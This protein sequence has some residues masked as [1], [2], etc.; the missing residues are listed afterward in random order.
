MVARFINLA[1]GQ[2]IPVL[3]IEVQNDKYFPKVVAIL[4]AAS[5]LY[6]IIEWKQSSRKSRYSLWSIA[7]IFT[8]L[9]FACISFWFSHSLIAKGTSFE[10]ISPVWYFTFF[11]IGF[12]LGLIVFE[13]TFALLMIRTPK[14]AKKLRLPRVPLATR[15]TFIVCFP[16]IFLLV[17][18]YYVFSIFSPEPIKGLAFYLFCI[19]IIIMFGEGFF[20]LFVKRDDNGKLIPFSK[21]I[22][23]LKKSYD[24]HDYSYL[25]I[26]H[27]NQAV[28]ELQISSTDSP[29][30]IQKVMQKRF[31]AKAIHFHV[32][33]EEEIQVSFYQKDGNPD[34][35][36]PSNLGVRIHKDCGK[37]G[38]LRVL[39]IFDDSSK[40][41]RKMEIPISLIETHAEDYLSNHSGEELAFRKV[42]SYAINQTVINTMNEE[43]GPLLYR[44]VMS[45]QKDI[46]QELIDKGEEVNIC[47]EY[48]WTSLLAASAQGYTIIM[49]MLLDAGANPDIANINGITPLMYGAR[50]G[51][52]DICRILIEYGAALDI[53]DKF[54]WTALIIASSEGH[55]PIVELLLESKAN[56]AIKTLNDMTALDYAHKNSHGQ[57]ATK[58]RLAK[59]NIQSRK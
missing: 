8:S 7:R 38:I 10:G 34:N 48:G 44:A 31:S 18:C 25:I 59:R 40:D 24:F 41:S 9:L 27:G 50:Y 6:L 1:P 53:Q 14:E 13:V 2:T 20:S 47:A 55:L 49:R 43:D 54:G 12:I 52:I 26:E 58:L 35:V 11:I 19:P 29:I 32:Q 5:V 30:D 37:K 21:R 36:V 56:P 45:G 28:K 17:L 33:Q 22:E 51:N 39:V 57:I 15:P 3:D 46:V 42:F 16:I 23:E 4:L